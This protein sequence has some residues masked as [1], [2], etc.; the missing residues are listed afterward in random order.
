MLSPAPVVLAPPFGCGGSLRLLQAP[1][2]ALALLVFAAS[3]SRADTQTADLNADG[4]PDGIQIENTARSATL[5]VRISG[6][7]GLIVIR[8][9]EPIAS[10]RAADVDR[11]GD[12][13][14]VAVSAAR[15]VW[16]WRNTGHGRFRLVRKSLRR[17]V[18]SPTLRATW[19]RYD[20]PAAP[21][22]DELGSAT[23]VWSDSASASM[24]LVA[25]C[26]APALSPS[27]AHRTPTDTMA[28]RAPPASPV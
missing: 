1:A 19:Q 3:P 12:L 4:V 6:Q 16:T 23:P 28:P 15:R 26:T 25:D 10:V 8:V 21:P 17:L 7:T 5:K 20:E 22:R 11:D 14:L 13:D 18:T 9:L 24:V 2:C 27:R